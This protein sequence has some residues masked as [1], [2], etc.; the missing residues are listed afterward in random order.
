MLQIKEMRVF[1]GKPCSFVVPF[2]GVL[3]EELFCALFFSFLYSHYNFR[4]NIK[5]FNLH[6]SQITPKIRFIYSVKRLFT[7]CLGRAPTLCFDRYLNK[8]Q[9]IVCTSSKCLLII[10][11][12]IKTDLLALFLCVFKQKGSVLC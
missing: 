2:W 3:K 7:Y 6:Y 11:Q 4:N 9:I 12:V 1:V 10:K 5:F 8:S